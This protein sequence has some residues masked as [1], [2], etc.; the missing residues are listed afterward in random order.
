MAEAVCVLLRKLAN[1][2]KIVVCVIHQPSS[3]TFNLFTHLCLLAKGRMAYL[4]ELPKAVDYFASIG[5]P[6][7]GNF[8]PADFFI[9]EL[10][11][12]PSEYEKSM[13]RLRVVTDAYA[14]SELRKTNDRWI[15]KLDPAVVGKGPRKR[16]AIAITEYP[17][18]ARTQFFES[19]KRTIL[20]V[21]FHWVS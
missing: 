10:A 6:C 1:T 17:A 20:Q 5:H 11:V 16:T 9:E 14:N 2:G 3:D 4:G 12:V 8:N 15:S 18:T 21:S 7:P 13:A 19:C